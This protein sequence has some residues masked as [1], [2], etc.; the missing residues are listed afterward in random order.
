MSVPYVPQ[1]RVWKPVEIDPN[2]TRDKDSYKD[3]VLLAESKYKL[4]SLPGPR[5]VTV[6]RKQKQ[7][8]TKCPSNPDACAR[9]LEFRLCKLPYEASAIKSLYP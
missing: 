4:T 6:D 7:L 2:K 1:A 9:S 5:G 8:E 3:T